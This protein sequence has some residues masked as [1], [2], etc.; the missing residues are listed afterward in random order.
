MSPSFNGV[1][2]FRH[3]VPLILH[4]L[5]SVQILIF[6]LD[7]TQKNATK[8]VLDQLKLENENIPIFTMSQVL[9]E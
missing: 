2:L 7:T 6:T 4:S 9:Y 1:L 3:T 5:T 8:Y